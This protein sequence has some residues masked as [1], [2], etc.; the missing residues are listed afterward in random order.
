MIRN[1]QILVA[2]LNWGLGHA[3]RS[4]PII[5]D[6]IANQNLIT[7]ASDGASLSLLKSVFPE[8]PY[9]NLPA[10]DVKYPNSSMVVNMGFQLPKIASAIRSE[11]RMVHNWIE[12]NEVD[13]IIS[14]NRYGCYHSST[15]NIFISH[16]LNLQVPFSSVVNR[17]HANM[18]NEFSRIWIVD[19]ANRAL[20]GNLSDPKWLSADIEISYLGA[21]SRLDKMACDNKYEIAAILSGPEPQRTF[22]EEELCKKLARS[23]LKSI[24]VQGSKSA[25]Q[26]ISNDNLEIIP[27][28]DAP[29]LSKI[30][31]SSEMMICRSGYSTIMDLAKLGGNALFVPTPG[32]TEQIYLAKRLQYQK[33]A[34]YQKQGKIDIEHAWSQKIDFSGF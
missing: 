2:V 14:D 20:S 34:Q 25:E 13:I 7:I 19:D 1:K 21:Q 15:E 24:L 32:Q 30:I 28:A 17:L 26:I 18:V 33:L 16:Q 6:L 3:T 27:F 22:L 5:R 31:C 12:K 11:R 23:N 8:L 9:I 4:I 10:Y 29:L